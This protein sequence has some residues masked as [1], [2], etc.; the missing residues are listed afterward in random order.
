MG[1]RNLLDFLKNT[2]PGELDESLNELGEKSG[3]IFRNKGADIE[4]TIVERT[5][6]MKSEEFVW[7]CFLRGNFLRGRDV[8]SNKAF[9]QFIEHCEKEGHHNYYFDGFPGGNLLPM[10]KPKFREAAGIERVLQQVREKFAGILKASPPKIKTGISSVIFSSSRHKDDAEVRYST[11]RGFLSF[12]V[13]RDTCIF[14]EEYKVF[15]STTAQ[16]LKRSSMIKGSRS[17]GFRKAG[18]TISISLGVNTN[19]QHS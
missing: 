4:K 19:V 5:K 1:I 3:E 6:N 13:I 2:D 9:K 11:S 10:F 17:R 12:Y 15:L 18:N 8:V 7:F 14:Y 16:P